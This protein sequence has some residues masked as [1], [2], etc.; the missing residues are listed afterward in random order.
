[1]DQKSERRTVTVPEAARL[2]GINP[3]LAYAAAKRGEIPSI[4]VGDR[5]LIPRAALERMLE[6]AA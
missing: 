6:G 1:M 5:V 4:K 2:L 3:Q